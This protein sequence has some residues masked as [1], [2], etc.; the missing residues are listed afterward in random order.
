[1]TGH[2]GADRSGPEDR[3]PVHRKCLIGDGSPEVWPSQ[4]SPSAGTAR[5]PVSS[6]NAEGGGHRG[7]DAHRGEGSSDELHERG[8]SW[9]RTSDLTLIRGAL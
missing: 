1:M 2:P 5:D 4:G 8:A 6:V 3:D 7:G 9:I